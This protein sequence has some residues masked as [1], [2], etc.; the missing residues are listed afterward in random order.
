MNNDL[1]A[2]H[3]APLPDEMQVPPVAQAEQA[4]PAQ[5]E[6]QAQAAAVESPHLAAIGSTVQSLLLEWRL[7][8][9]SAQV[10]PFSG[11][12]A[13][14][15]RSWLRDMARIGLTLHNDDEKLKVLAVQTLKGSASD[16]VSRILRANPGTSWDHLRTQ[17][18]NRFSDLSDS[19]YALVTLRRLRQN[20]SESVQSYSEKLLEL[21]EEAFNTLDL[22]NQYIQR[23]LIDIFIQGVRDDRVARKVI[24][25][26]PATLDQALRL[27]TEEQL[28][29]RT[30]GLHRQ[31][32]ERVE[33]P[34]EVGIVNQGRLDRLEG[35]VNQLGGLVRE[36]LSTTNNRGPESNQQTSGSVGANT[37]PRMTTQYQWTANNKPICAYCSIPGHTQRNCR[38]KRYDMA[39][40]K[41]NNSSHSQSNNQGN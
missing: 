7:Q 27:A 2:A 12:S 31:N 38:K 21:A 34:M 29:S 8:G 9:L 39:N 19:Q 4:Q 16:F 33:T 26:Q 36:V 35:A 13:K 30:F 15:L 17:I 10:K 1:E 6:Q 11:E 22:S 23:Q 3:L 40:N 20:P 25:R 37:R 5:V 24:A 32:P 41:P 14:N 18:V 28:T